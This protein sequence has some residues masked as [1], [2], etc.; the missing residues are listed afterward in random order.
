MLFLFLTAATL[1]LPT[2]I[3]FFEVSGNENIPAKQILAA[4][5]HCG[6]SFA[7]SRSQVRSE[8]VKNELLSMLPQLQWAGINTSGC[9]A[10][11]SVRERT[12]QEP[13]RE[14]AIV[15]DLISEQD[16][17]VLSA[18]VISGTAM[19]Q[20]GDIIT[21]GQILVSGYTD[22][23]L[24][25]QAT[26][27]CGEILAQTNRDLTAVIPATYLVPG[28]ITETKY[29]YSLLVGKK[30][31]NLWKDSRIF[32]AVCGRM[33]EEYFV[34]LPGG[35]QL[36]LALCIDRYDFYALQDVTKREAEVLQE[37]LRFSDAYLVRRMTAG[38]ILQKKQQLIHSEGVYILDSH[39]TC[40][41]IIG[42]ERREK[43][44]EHD[45]KRS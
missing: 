11:I 2:R 24:Y 7:A 29:V 44:G 33:Y 17:Y 1:V 20:P 28:P 43:I 25:I 35:F 37:L 3:L 26:R 19:V 9:R 27:A 34:T 39:Y 42:K 21:K 6:I 12:E 22:C 10:V 15:S 8:K 16:G 18:T 4:A 30:R 41:E 14:D 5:E 38:R 31:I 36:P 40:T 45:G 23:G 32:D 13:H